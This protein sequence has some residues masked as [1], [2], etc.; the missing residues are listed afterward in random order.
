M[1]LTVAKSSRCIRNMFVDYVD[2][3]LL[4]KTIAD[5][6]AANNAVCSCFLTSLLVTLHTLS[7]FP[8]C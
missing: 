8:T 4:Q 5:S 3:C 7:E 2:H 1:H 6:Y